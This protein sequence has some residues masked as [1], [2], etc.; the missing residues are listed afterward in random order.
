MADKQPIVT[1]PFP[2]KVLEHLLAGIRQLQ[3]DAAPYLLVLTNEQRSTRLKMGAKSVMFVTKAFNYASATLT[4]APFGIDVA[5]LGTNLG[6][7][8]GIAPVVAALKQLVFDLEGTGMVASG[9]A[10][11][12]G[13]AIYNETH[14]QANRNVPGAQAAFNDMHQQYVQ[15]GTDSLPPV[16]GK[17]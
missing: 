11:A 4:F 10:K 5:G 7:T 6:T 17:A 13:L 12:G 9:S 8:A 14:A 1:V 15:I 2:A 3:A 16:P